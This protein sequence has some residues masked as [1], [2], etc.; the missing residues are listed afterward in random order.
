MAISIFNSNYYKSYRKV[1][2]RIDEA[3]L[4]KDE[5]QMMYKSFTVL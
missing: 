2:D 3:S 1:K 4:F 5:S